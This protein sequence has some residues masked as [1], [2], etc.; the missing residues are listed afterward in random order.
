MELVR[1]L[2]SS[3]PFS[4]S[5]VTL[6]LFALWDFRSSPSASS[7]FSCSAFFF[8]F[9]SSFSFYSTSSCF[10]LFLLPLM[11]LFLLCLSPT[12][13]FFP[14]SLS[15]SPL[16]FITFYFP[17]SLSSED[18][19]SQVA[20]TPNKVDPRALGLYIIQ[21]HQHL[22]H[23]SLFSKKGIE[24][25]PQNDNLLNLSFFS[26]CIVHVMFAHPQV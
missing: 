15:S 25:N 26:L 19:R 1:D 8:L 2:T 12:L 7:F 4:H 13:S 11:F 23:H 21:T 22:V 20:M 14:P 10:F 9:S 16:S 17:S 5:L 6:M 18:G 3:D 24:E